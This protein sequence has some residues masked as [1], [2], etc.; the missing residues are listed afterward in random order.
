MFRYT[1]ILLMIGFGSISLFAQNDADAA[2]LLEDLSAKYRTYKTSV[3]D[4]NLTIDVPEVDE[5]TVLKSKVWLKGDQFKIEFDDKILMSNTV[6]QW[7]YLKEVNELQISNYDPAAMI[8][9]PSKLF[10]LYSDEYIYRIVEEYKNSKGELIKKVELTPLN[11]ELEI[12][13]IVT[14]INT[15]TLTLVNTKMFEKSGFKYSYEIISL[16]T[17]MELKDAFFSFD[18]KAYNIDIDD[19]TDLR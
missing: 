3:L 4:V 5:S 16:K 15:N 2:Q 12:F 14:A 13:K 6:S 1:I 19:I 18:S 8:F 11:K 7:T 17:N 9:L 10:D